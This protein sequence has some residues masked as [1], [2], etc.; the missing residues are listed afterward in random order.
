MATEQF[1]IFKLE[2]ERFGAS[3]DQ[4]MSITDFQSL[5]KIPES[6]EYI[7]GLLNLRG[8]VIPVLNLKKKFKIES[9]TKSSR[10]I[11]ANNSGVLLGLL[12]DDA[13]QSMTKESS[14]IMGAPSVIIKKETDYIKEVV[15][16]EDELILIIDLFKLVQVEELEKIQESVK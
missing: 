14:D 16:H 5:S 4:I 8:D 1:I 3:I 2:D 10:I 9:K 12:V 6:P 7:E 15:A 11:I 13:S